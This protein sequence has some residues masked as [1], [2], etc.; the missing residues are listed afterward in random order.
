L[1]YTEPITRTVRDAALMLQVCAGFDES[2]PASARVPMLD[3]MTKLG[4]DI[5]GMKVGLPVRLYG[6]CAPVVRKVFDEALR[7]F[8]C[9]GAELVEVPCISVE[10]MDRIEY[11]AM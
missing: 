9:L 4:H 7:V 5:R 3:F 10:E 6:D 1:D 11:P 8:E 2:D